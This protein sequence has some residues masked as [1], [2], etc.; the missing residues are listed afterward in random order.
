MKR[1]VLLL[2]FFIPAFLCEGQE[3]LFSG[4]ASYISRSPHPGFGFGVSMSRIYFDF[5]GNWATGEGVNSDFRALHSYPLEKENVLVVNA[6]YHFPYKKKWLITPFLGV[7]A[8]RR[9][10]E[11]ADGFD[12]YSYG[13]TKTKLS[14][15]VSGTYRFADLLGVSLGIGTVEYVKAGFV[16][17]IWSKR[18]L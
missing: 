1:F 3:L 2:L 5:S 16:I 17:G 14:I 7:G 11:N 8:V 12:S 15:G 6:G 9:I 18:R 13:D 4:T 10:Y